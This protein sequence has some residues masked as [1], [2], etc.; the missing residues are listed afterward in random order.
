MSKKWHSISEHA[1]IREVMADEILRVLLSKPDTKWNEKLQLLSR[2]I[3]YALY[4]SATSLEEYSDRKTFK[5]RLQLLAHQKNAQK[6]T[7]ISEIPST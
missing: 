3:E 1:P 2:R 6:K 5:L 7:S 4:H